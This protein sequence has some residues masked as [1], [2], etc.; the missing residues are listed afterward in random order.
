M[1]TRKPVKDNAHSPYVAFT[2]D[3]ERRLALMSRDVRTVVIAL[4]LVAGGA[5]T[6]PLWKML[7]GLIGGP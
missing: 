2:D 7:W 1:T 3:R 6:A 5:T 4:I